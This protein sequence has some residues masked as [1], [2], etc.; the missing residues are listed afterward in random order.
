MNI[1]LCGYNWSGCEALRLLKEKKNNIFVYTHKS[2]YFESDL[3]EYCKINKV[4]YTLSSISLKNLPFKPDLIIS[5]SYRFKIP[6]EVLKIS[7]FKPFNLHPSLLPKYKGCSSIPW[8]I[9][10]NEKHTGF[11]YHYMTENYDRGNIILQKKVGISKFDLQI[12][13]Y[14]KV[15]FESLKYFNQVV[16]LVKKNFLGKKQ[17][18]SGT[19]FKRGAPFD[20]KLNNEWSAQKKKRFIKSMIFPPRPLAKY[21]KKYI[22]SINDLNK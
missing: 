6:T 4:K 15:M 19:Y 8:V 13:L 11:S 14:Y 22:K 2:N 12:T 10:N 21:K 3:E 20:G 17:I 18:G 1:I 9:I 16:Q 5:I 7:K